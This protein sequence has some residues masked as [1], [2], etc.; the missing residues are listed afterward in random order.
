MRK[1]IIN[2]STLEPF[3]SNIKGDKMVKSRKN[4]FHLEVSNDVDLEYETASTTSRRIKKANGKGKTLTKTKKFSLKA[5]PKKSGSLLVVNGKK[6]PLANSKKRRRNKIAVSSAGK[7]RAVSAKRLM[8]K[9][10]T[11][12]SAKK[13][14]SLEGKKRAV[15]SKSAKKVMLKKKALNKANKTAKTSALKKKKTASSN[16]GKAWVLKKKAPRANSQKMLKTKSS[17][18]ATKKMLPSMDDIKE[19]FGVK[20]KDQKNGKTQSSSAGTSSAKKLMPSSNNRKLSIHVNAKKAQGSNSTGSDSAGTKTIYMPIKQSDS[21]S[22][23]LSS[24]RTNRRLRLTCRMSNLWRLKRK[25]N[26]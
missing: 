22:Q 16:T 15:A 2:P 4:N 21:R 25:I 9:A 24:L 26:Y 18:P 6:I 19:F 23:K 12:K 20:E 14:S 8:K 11:N 10:S 17:P 3:T 7:K 5:K 13:A 1:C